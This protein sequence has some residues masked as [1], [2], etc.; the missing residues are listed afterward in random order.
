MLAGRSTMPAHRPASLE[1]IAMAVETIALAPESATGLALA[2][3]DA[4]TSKTGKKP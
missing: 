1:G 2:L 4:A 3:E